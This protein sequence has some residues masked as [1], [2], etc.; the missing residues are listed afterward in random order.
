MIKVAVVIALVWICSIFSNINNSTID[1]A[2][3]MALIENQYETLHEELLI[4]KHKVIALKDTLLFEEHQYKKKEVAL[5][6][7][8]KQD[9]QAYVTVTFYHPATGGINTDSDPSMTATMTKPRSGI[10]IAISTSLVKK[11]WLGRNIYID[12]YGMFIAE[13]RMNIGLKG[14]RIDV[15][16]P[17]LAYALKK[18]RT[19]NVLACP[20]N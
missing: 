19:H 14:D 9:H 10:T 16:A 8:Y 18:G 6:N 2:Y 5:K 4:E 3:D 1:H 13:D 20:I 7:K 15:C 11:G 12:G 17:T